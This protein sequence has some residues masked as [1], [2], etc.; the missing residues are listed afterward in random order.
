M[1]PVIA[2]MVH[3]R[4]MMWDCTRSVSGFVEKHL[5]IAFLCMI[6]VKMTIWSHLLVLLIAR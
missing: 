2:Q 6:S 3:D 4:V 5:E 1:R